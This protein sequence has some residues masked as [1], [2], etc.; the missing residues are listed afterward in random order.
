MRAKE[1]FTYIIE[2]IIDPQEIFLF[3]QKRANLSD[4]EMYGTYNMGMDYAIFLP[5]RDVDQ[6][7]KV[8]TNN[9]FTSINAGYV[10]KGERQVIIKPKSLVYKTGTLDLR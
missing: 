2:K 5:E 9:G 1:N 3:I 8:I 10:K 4:K 7:Q 6:A